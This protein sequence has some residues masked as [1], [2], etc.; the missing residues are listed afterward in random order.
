MTDTMSMTAIH[1][2]LDK[3]P[4]DWLARQA[5]ADLYEGAGED[6]LAYCQRVCKILHAMSFRLPILSGN[7]LHG[8]F[9]MLRTGGIAQPA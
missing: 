4:W 8:G 5:L 7:L 1:Q 9:E 2:H 3:E 6:D